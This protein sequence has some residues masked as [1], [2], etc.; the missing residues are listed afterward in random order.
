MSSE[1]VSSQENNAEAKLVISAQAKQQAREQLEQIK[2]GTAEIIPEAE[3]LGKLERSIASGKPLR[4]KLGVD[5]STSDLHLGHSVV[6]QKLK[7]FQDLGHQVLFLIG[8]FTAQIGDP[9]GKS[10]TRKQLTRDEVK[11]HSKT[12]SDQVLKVLNPSKTQI[13]FNSQWTDSLKIQDVIR[14][15]SQI[16]VARLLERDDFSKRYA[17]Q[18]PISIHEFLYPI[19]QAFDSVQLRA[20][21]ELGGTDQKFNV[22]LGRDYQKNAGQEPQV[23]V[24]VPILE[25]TDGVLKMSKSLNNAIGITEAPKDIFG[26]IMSLTDKLMFKYYELLT[27][28]DLEKIKEMHPKEAKVQLAHKLVERFHNTEE[29][30]LAASEFDSVFSKKQIP[31]DI[32]TVIVS[33]HGIGLAKVLAENDV[34]SS[35]S[36]ARRLIAQGAVSVNGEKITDT[37]HMIEDTSEALVKAGKRK[38]IKVLF[39]PQQKTKERNSD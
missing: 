25:G 10:E 13:V 27:N 32:P 29:A 36:E 19:V 30:D 34:V 2:R 17:S 24:L 26:K 38:F 4:I 8:D 15:A 5:P 35:L 39:K 3:L 31:N 1:E 11:Q 28:E 33:A 16:T 37:A 12:Y 7:V 22:L 23:V 20:D 18:Q 9:T 6:L 21:V 14:L